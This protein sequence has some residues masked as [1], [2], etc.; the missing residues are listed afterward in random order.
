MIEMIPRYVRINTN[1][2]KF[3]D[4]I[5]KISDS[6]K[7]ESYTDSDMPIPRLVMSSQCSTIV[8]H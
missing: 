6:F 4:A 8:N 7:L 2:I 5:K 1:K 3:D